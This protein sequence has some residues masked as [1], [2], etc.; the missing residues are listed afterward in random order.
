MDDV[1]TLPGMVDWRTRAVAPDIER[2]C[3]RRFKSLSTT[4]LFPAK[5]AQKRFIR[6]TRMLR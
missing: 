2:E 1:Q 5:E 3:S 4:T 6:G